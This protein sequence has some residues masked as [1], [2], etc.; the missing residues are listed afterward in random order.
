MRAPK[1]YIIGVLCRWGKKS[2]LCEGN[3]KVALQ[4]LRYEVRYKC[5]YM[6]WSSKWEDVHARSEGFPILKDG[7]GT[8][9]E[10]LDGFIDTSIEKACLASNILKAQTI[11]Q[12]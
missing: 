6:I 10:S 9:K 2:M 12:A 4:A 11:H 1:P 3:P 5:D 8:S 7:A